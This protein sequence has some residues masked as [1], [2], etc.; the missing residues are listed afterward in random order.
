M[1]VYHILL[2]SLTKKAIPALSGNIIVVA[3]GTELVSR[4]EDILE[5]QLVRKADSSARLA[6]LADEFKS[7]H[8]DPVY[9]QVVDS[10][11]DRIHSL[12]C[13][14]M[15]L[16]FRDSSLTSY[17]KAMLV[18]LSGQ[19]VGAMTG[20]A[21]V[22]DGRE[23][24]VCESN[25][26][27]PVVDWELTGEKISGLSGKGLTVVS[28]SYGRKV[29]GET[30]DLGARGSELTASIIGAV[31]GADAVRFIVGGMPSAEA[32][33][34]TYDEAAQLFSGGVPV[35]P[36]SLIPAR[37]AGVPV[38]ICDLSQ[39]C[40][41]VLE[42]GRPLSDTPSGKIT[43]VV[44]SGPMTLFTVYGTGLLGSVGISSA[45]FGALAHRGVN[46]HFISQSL[47][48]YSISFAVLRDASR[49]ASEALAELV[50]ETAQANFND[51]SFDMRD[52]RIVSVFGQGMRHVPGI[53]AKVYSVLGSAGIN[54]VASS[55]GGEE[56]SISVVVSDPDAEPARTALLTLK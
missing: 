40:A 21:G 17:L 10:A 16:S 56:L 8:D 51:L 47:S 26:G 2:D 25:K 53:S 45:I 13:Q 49:M 48:E 52:V 37:K 46:I 7:L 32:G 38:E 19:A 22:V 27:I 29:T 34:I 36:P 24:I 23:I 42:I 54:V 39:D 9:H 43:G 3:P 50:G 12:L 31:L 33:R 4:F 14:A 1:T 20:A 35:Y 44:V 15:S 28:G 11:V 30:V 18:S 6:A 55:Q 5:C 41:V